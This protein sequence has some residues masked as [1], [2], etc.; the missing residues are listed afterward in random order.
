MP[1]QSTSCIWIF[2]FLLYL[3]ILQDLELSHKSRIEEFIVDSTSGYHSQYSTRPA[4]H[5]QQSVM[6][7]HEYCVPPNDATYFLTMF[8][9]AKSKLH[10]RTYHYKPS[11]IKTWTDRP[12]IDKHEYYSGTNLGLTN[13][14]MAPGEFHFKSN[15]SMQFLG[16]VSAF[17]QCSIHKICLTLAFQTLH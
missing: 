13:L 7:L 17:A 11:N 3:F 14:S 10:N 5:K 2:S 9:F 12:P 6:L 1:F 16:Y 15:L 8:R 4:L